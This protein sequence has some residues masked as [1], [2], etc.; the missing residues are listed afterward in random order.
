M[1]AFISN[2]SGFAA[3]IE[4]L[5]PTLGRGFLITLKLFIWTL[6]LSLPLGLLVSLIREGVS[7]KPTDRGF[8]KVIKA[9]IRL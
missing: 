5:L 4:S 1:T 7:A 2:I 8:V 6:A 3:Y 9:P